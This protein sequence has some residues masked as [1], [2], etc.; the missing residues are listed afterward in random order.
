M[1]NIALHPDAP[2]PLKTKCP[3]TSENYANVGSTYTSGCYNKDQ[4]V[5]PCMSYKA[6]KSNDS[7]IGF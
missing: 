2:A 1:R 7:F 6:S 3:D 5:S 4:K